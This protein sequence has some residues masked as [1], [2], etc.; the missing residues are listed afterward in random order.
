MRDKLQK[1]K[2]KRI[3]WRELLFHLHNKY[4]SD[5]YTLALGKY[6]KMSHNRIAY[7]VLKK[8][9]TTATLKFLKNMF[10]QSTLTEEGVAEW[11]RFYVRAGLKDELC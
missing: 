7:Y 8:Y 9:F 2:K 5:R 3:N 6:P 11:Y 4:L 1:V 10:Q